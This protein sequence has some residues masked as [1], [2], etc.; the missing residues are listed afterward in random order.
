MS[1][2]PIP[3][4]I[5]AGPTP[6]KKGL[7]VLAWVAIGC[8][9]LL[10]IAGL[11]VVAGGFFVAR[12]VGK[13]AHNPEM[14]AAKLVVA[15]NPDLEIVSTDEGAGTLTIRNKKTGEVVTMDLSQIK[16]GKLDFTGPKGEKLSIDAEGKEGQ[17]TLNFHSDQGDVTFGAGT[18]DK[19][20]A[21]IPEYPGSAPE[22]TT[23]MT[24]KMRTA[25]GFTFKVP[26]APQAV[27][28]RYE[29]AFKAAG[30]E[31]GKQTFSGGGS[32][33]GVVSAK[34]GGRSA[35]VSVASGD[36]GTTVMVNF[37]E[38]KAE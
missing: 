4:P 15:A 2:P 23:S 14:A 19:P 33:G 24:D 3:P 9:A 5:P 13:A 34:S 1:Q 8:G 28:D 16:K 21:W 12:T 18:G 36:D 25:G 37:E 6:R 10:L 32:T 11:A 30:F 29:A 38:K 17:G 27:L 20:P 22:G 35:A 31:T 26:D 7:P